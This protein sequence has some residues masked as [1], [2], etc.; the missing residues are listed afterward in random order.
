MWMKQ[1]D[2]DPQ[3]SSIIQAGLNKL[4]EYRNRADLTPAYVIAM[5]MHLDI[6][7]AYT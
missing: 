3:T 1:Q 4:E 7:L 2:D 6:A 5:S